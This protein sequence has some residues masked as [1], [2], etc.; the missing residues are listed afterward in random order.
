MAGAH[1]A[2]TGH[3][4]GFT[5]GLLH[6]LSGW[7]HLLAMIAV[8]VWAVRGG[9]RAIRL[10][11]L[12]FVSTM[13]LGGLLGMIARVQIPLVEQGI[14]VSVLILGLFVA[15]RV[16]LPLWAG[17]M[18]VGWFALFHG[19]AHGAEMPATA[20]GWLYGAGFVI[21]TVGLHLAGIGLGLAMQ[22]MNSPVPVRIVGGA[23]ALGGAYLLFNA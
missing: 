14:A 19:F 20:S 2:L 10:L 3:T 8:G 15:W 13:I 6:P 17:A 23:M 5:N 9:R 1:P 18:V 22:K 21:A 11:P 16:R 7:D 4:H 12:A